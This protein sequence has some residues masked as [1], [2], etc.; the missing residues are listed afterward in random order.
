PFP[1]APIL[2]G[3]RPGTQRNSLQIK[4]PPGDGTEPG[5]PAVTEPLAAALR[6]TALLRPAPRTLS[7]PLTET[8]GRNFTAPRRKRHHRLPSGG[9]AKYRSTRTTARRS[10]S[11]NERRTAGSVSGRAARRSRS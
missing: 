3:G 4:A 6:R 9:S 5:G 2:L 10:S 8:S 1:L 11:P 7:Q